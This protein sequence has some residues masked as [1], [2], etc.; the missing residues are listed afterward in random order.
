MN[1][2][3]LNKDI[4]SLSEFRSNAST[5]IKQVHDTKRPLVITKHGRSTAVILDINEYED[6]V[7]MNE[8]LLDIRKAEEQ[9]VT[10]QGISHEKAKNIILQ[11]IKG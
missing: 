2:L 1:R 9:L 3:L 8:L 10:G 6:L 7:R 11:Q 5:L 4:L